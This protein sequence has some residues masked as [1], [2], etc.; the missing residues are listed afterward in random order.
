MWHA[1]LT[2]V[3][4]A[5]AVGGLALASVKVHAARRDPGPVL[6]LTASSL[7]HAAAIFLLATPGGYRA[8]GDVAGVPHL[9]ALLV[10]CLGLLCAGHAHVLVHLWHP[11]DRTRAAPRRTVIA[12]SL[13]YIGAAAAMTA[14][15]IQADPRAPARPL[16][17]AADHAR[18][19]GVIAFHLV[20]FTALLAVVTATV[21]KC[22]ALL[23]A[24]AP[25]LPPE[26]R[27][28]VRGFA[29]AAALNLVHAVCIL[30]AMAGA[31]R[32]HR[33]DV[34]A[35]AAWLTTA[36]SGVV[37][38]YSLVRLPLRARR[39]ERRDYQTLRPLWDTVV[40]AEPQ[41]VLAP[42]VLWGGWDTRIALSRRLVEIRDGA[43]SLSPW[44]TR[45]PADAVARLVRDSGGA[46]ADRDVDVVAAQAAATLLYAAEQRGAGHPP[47][48]PALRLPALP[49]EDV[50]AAGE[51]AHLVL[52]ARHLHHPVVLEALALARE[53]SGMTCG[54]G[55]A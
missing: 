53:Q 50:P 8:V 54:A 48:P 40:R 37:A 44:M 52:V 43:R 7:F 33:L 12:W 47:A 2:S 49:G 19:P 26:L 28:C 4:L 29:A 25:V 6:T 1:V 20:Y 34:L 45:A 15:F 13:L 14:L 3:S 31:A 17:L 55:R 46:D 42:G 32:G 23:A 5:V 16:L 11:V 9:A 18:E 38:N 27:R 21:L 24:R 36:V 39:R 35:E 22:R 30:T 10:H 51:R 41:L